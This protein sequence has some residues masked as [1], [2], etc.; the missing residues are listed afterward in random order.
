MRLPVAAAATLVMRIIIA[1][2]AIFIFRNNQNGDA[3]VER[4]QLAAKCFNLRWNIV[5]AFYF[6]EAA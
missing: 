2:R 4:Y 5:C 3:L 6:A 1:I